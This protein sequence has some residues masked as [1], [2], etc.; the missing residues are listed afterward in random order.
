MKYL[1]L[2][3]LMLSACGS[4]PTDEEIA[5][6]RTLKETWILCVIP[7]AF[8]NETDTIDIYVKWNE[9]TDIYMRGLISVQ[10]R[11]GTVLKSRDLPYWDNEVVN[12]EFNTSD[13]TDGVIAVRLGY[14]M[15]AEYL[16]TGSQY[17]TNFHSFD[18]CETM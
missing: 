15:S 1:I 7:D 2:L 6:G 4:E 16:A 17:D 8:P 5:D 18:T 14:A 9:Y 11:D 12:L 10:K 3:T 13:A